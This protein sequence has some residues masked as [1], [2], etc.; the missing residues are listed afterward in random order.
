MVVLE[1][2]IKHSFFAL[3]LVVKIT[4]FAKPETISGQLKKQSY[5]NIVNAKKDESTYHKLF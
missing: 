1:F 2:K 4:T 3:T 5:T